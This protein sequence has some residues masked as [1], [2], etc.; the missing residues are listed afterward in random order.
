MKTALLLIDIQNDYFKGG[1]CE[2]HK[3]EEAV[4]NGF[5]VLEYFRNN[6][7]SVF[8]IKHFST[9]KNSSILKKGSPGAEIHKLVS[10]KGNERV[11]IKSFPNSFRDTNLQEGLLEQEITDLV[12][13]GM[14]SQHCVDSTVRA[15][16][17]LGYNI[18]LLHD[19]CA[20][21]DLE[22]D[23]R[24]SPAGQVQTAFMAS[25]GRGFSKVIPTS[26]FLSKPANF[27]NCI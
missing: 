13:A 15:A 22:F 27:T 21:R 6:S 9:K 2:L 14:M 23:N 8:H 12:V 24:K 3:S 18:T 4:A 20:T 7:L 16:F 17:D 25:L 26:E 1:Q 11:I 19:A 10:P 5:R